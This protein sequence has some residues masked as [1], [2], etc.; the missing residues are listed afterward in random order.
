MR[1]LTRNQA[2]ADDIAQDA[3][4]LAF[5]RLD[6]FSGSGS[7]HSWL[8]S[9]AYRCFLQHQRQLKRRDSLAD[10][11]HP[12]IL[13]YQQTVCAGM[14][15][16]NIDLERAMSQLQPNQAAA[17]TLNLN[18]GYSHAEVSG[19][20]DMP[21]GTVKSQIKRGLKTLR[22]HMSSSDCKPTSEKKP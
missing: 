8:L 13:G 3:F 11:G 4:V 16:V 10:L 1:K 22:E 5:R 19:I 20:L 17:I 7:F 15:A 9:I 2:L 12:A 18:M 14:D 6:Q 21:L